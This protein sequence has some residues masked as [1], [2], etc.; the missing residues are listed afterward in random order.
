MAE[1]T[2]DVRRDIEL[3][4]ERMSSTIEELEQKLNVTQMVRD[5]PWPALALAVGAGVLLSGS[6]ADVK[7]AAA[8]VTATKG[9]SSKL[10]SALDDVVADLVTAATGALHGHVDKLVDEVKQMIGAPAG[11]RSAVKTRGGYGVGPIDVTPG[12][13]PD[14]PMSVARAD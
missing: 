9:A 6:R 3:T 5:H 1:T 14:V 4:R 11:T 13:L 8:T 12:E 10:G 7:A 2:A